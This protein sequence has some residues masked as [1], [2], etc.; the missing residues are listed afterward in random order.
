MKPGHETPVNAT[1]AKVVAKG[2]GFDF[3][4]DSTI[5][6]SPLPL[7]TEPIPDLLRNTP[8]FIDFTG[9]K[10]GRL[11]V[12]G[13]SSKK[14]SKHARW[15]CKCVC[16]NYCLRKS[17][18]LKAPPDQVI[19]VCAQCQLLAAHKVKELTRRTGQT[20]RTKEFL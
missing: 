16:G 17:K 12:I 10:I 20:T 7:P 11:T 18:T 19:Q 9:L 6:C 3:K 14:I 13:L 8:A 2:E 1:A 5:V 15:V 4:Q